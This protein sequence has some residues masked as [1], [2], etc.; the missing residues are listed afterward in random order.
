MNIRILAA[1]A[2]AL[3][4]LVPAA[5]AASEHG[6][7]SNGHGERAGFARNDKTDNDCHGY[8]NLGT[9]QCKIS[10]ASFNAK[11]EPRVVKTSAAK[12]VRRIGVAVPNPDRGT[13]NHPSQL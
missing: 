1:S 5:N 6:G 7:R 4:I 12:I 10:G 11:Y 8:L 3:A 9:A 2:L 13:G